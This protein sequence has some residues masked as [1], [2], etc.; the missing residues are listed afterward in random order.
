[1]GRKKKDNQLCGFCGENRA[2]T[3]DH[4]PPK[5]VFPRPRPN[6]LITVPACFRCNNDTS[7]L[8]EEFKLYLSFAVGVDDPQ[9]Q[10][11]WTDNAFRT[12]K[13][14]KRLMHQVIGS[15][16][17]V[18]VTVNGNL[19]DTLMIQCPKGPH[20]AILEKTVRGLYWHHFQLIL[21]DQAS[22]DVRLVPLDK[23]DVEM[24]QLMQDMPT[25]SVG[26]EQFR[27]WY[28]RDLEQPLCSG[29][30]LLFHK[31]HLCFALTEPK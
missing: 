2:E 19:A 3:V 27:Y 11:L 17:P 7:A 5:G 26:G 8:D 14:N 12:L 29:W 21:G 31:R 23:M 24:R 20:Y 28:W 1:M 6:D 15:A 4:V 22:V 10:A 30:F 9:T 16:R 18:Q 13:H 25:A